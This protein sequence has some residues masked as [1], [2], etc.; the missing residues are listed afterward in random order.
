MWTR[1][2]GGR[3]TCMYAKCLYELHV[4][5]LTG[6]MTSQLSMIMI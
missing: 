5:L 4:A 6:S 1:H 3:C 2:G